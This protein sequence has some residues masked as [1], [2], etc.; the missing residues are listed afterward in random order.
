MK[1][2]F[3]QVAAKV[4]EPVKA[5][6]RQV[7]QMSGRVL[8]RVQSFTQ[9]QNAAYAT[10]VAGNVMSFF[11]S[12]FLVGKLVPDNETDSETRA[13]L[14]TLASLAILVST[15]SALTVALVKITKL[16]I[17]NV[18]IVSISALIGFSI[19][20]VAIIRKED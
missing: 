20:T 5:F 11:I 8:A 13:N 17:S 16:P 2:D 7:G 14:K 9:N 6:A 18:R 15:Y 3:S 12:C 19:V 10:L 1:V 4:P